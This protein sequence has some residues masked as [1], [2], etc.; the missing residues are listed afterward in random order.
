MSLPKLDIQPER[1]T[2]LEKAKKAIHQLLNVIEELSGQ[3]IQLTNQVQEL[4]T[5][6]DRLRKQS[7]KP[8]FKQASEGTRYSAIKPRVKDKGKRGKKAKQVS[9]DRHEQL[10]E[11]AVCE[12]GS[13]DF[14]LV[15]T[16]NKLVQG[17]IIKRDNV[18]YH[19]RDKQCGTCGKLHRSTL[20]EGVH[21]QQFSAELR[22]LLSIF[23]YEC[24]MSEVLI[25]RFMIGLGV[26]ISSGEINRV[27]LG[28]SKKLTGG[29][30]HL[31]TRGLKLS[32]YI[33][34]DAT[35]FVRQVM[36]TGR[37]LRNHLHFVGHQY[38]SVFKITAKYNST[39]L[40]TKVLGKRV[41]QAIYI[42]DDASP[43]GEKLLIK[44]K[45]LCW[46]HEI[47]HYL[48]LTP[49]NK[50]YRIEV[51]K[52][53]DQLWRWYVQAKQYGRDPTPQKRQQIDASFDKI[54][55]GI[56][57]YNL[58]AKRLMLTGRK[59]KRLLCFLDHPGIPIEN[60]RAERDLREVVILRKISGGT[61]SVEGDRSFERHMSIIQTAHKQGLNVFD[62]VHGLLMGTLD[63]FVLTQKILPALPA[64]HSTPR[65]Y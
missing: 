52:V 4:Q 25:K 65:R 60:N 24:R 46:V 50:A 5:E 40:S 51:D 54:V 9:I 28:N 11:V 44:D 2:N 49:T 6:N 14:T 22:S 21:G 43:N 42:S 58:L 31:K 34:S 39:I 10:G 23:K 27:I 47:R 41:M 33:H 16:W 29:Y 35:G 20:P 18:M 17:L 56:A 64:P 7:G 13:K 3:V 57:Q 45:Q 8:T 63:P 1:I 12:C 55:E 19:G 53:I 15:R 61:K 38:I 26:T 36:K 37:R 30:T 62:T 59:K 48:K 32:S